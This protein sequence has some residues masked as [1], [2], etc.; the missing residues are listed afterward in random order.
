MKIATLH[1][2]PPYNFPLILNLLSRYHIAVDLSR[3]NFQEYWR[4]LRSGDGLALV[5]VVNTGTTDEPQLDVHI[6]ESRGTI[7]TDEILVM[8][9]QIL[10][11]DVDYRAFYD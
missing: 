3:N 10:C 1:P 9:C 5:R 6:V 2:I 7:N 8:L 4:T 11:T